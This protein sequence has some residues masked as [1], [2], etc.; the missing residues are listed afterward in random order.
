[1]RISRRTTIVNGTAAIAGL[2]L[3]AGLH[4]QADYPS[5]PITYLVPYPAGGL[6]DSVA[7]GVALKM[8]EVLGQPVVIE[9]KA[10]AGTSVAS[11]YAARQPPDGYMVYGGGTSLAINPALKGNEPYDPKRDFL[12]VSL[13]ARSAFVLHVH[14]SV[15]AN[16]LQELIA[17]LKANP[18][19]VDYA[20]SGVGATNHLQGEL[21]KRMAG[22]NINH[23]PYRGG[24]PA[25][26]DLSAGVVKM[27]FAAILE[28]MPLLRGGK[29]RPIAVSSKQ[30]V[31]VLPDVP[32]L[33]E[34]GVK[35]FEAIFWQALYVPA[36]TPKPIIAKLNAAV[37][38]ATSDAELRKRY[39]EQGADLE[40][41]TP[42]EL[43]ALLDRDTK[44]WGDLIR[45]QNIKSE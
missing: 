40:G 2:G 38:R 3:P 25:A 18:G 34:A 17:W 14:P 21:F 15:P 24:A 37:L 19:K 31:S 1:M 44:L 16:N 39:A 35:G 5:R 23:V 33:D 28:A 30:R 13:V 43:A 42:E 22:V 9:N 29:T 7:R 45:E 11:A 26:Q 32:S 4:A 36:N 8:T 10:G 41:S 6:N 27:M 20:S 12:P